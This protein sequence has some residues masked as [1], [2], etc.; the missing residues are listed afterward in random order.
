MSQA[1]TELRDANGVLF[2]LRPFRDHR[3]T[4]DFMV[5]LMRQIDALATVIRPKSP[6]EPH[7][8]GSFAQILLGQTHGMG[9]GKNVSGSLLFPGRS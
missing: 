3:L 5:L 4:C 9:N 2:G 8:R 6:T 7:K 1:P